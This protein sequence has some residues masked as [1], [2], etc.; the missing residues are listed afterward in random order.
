VESE[1]EAERL[2]RV[3]GEMGNRAPV[4]LRIN[5]D[6]DAKTHKKITT[7]KKENKFGIS[8]DRAMA[9]AKKMQKDMPNLVLQGLHC[10]VGSQILDPAV[11]T[12]V[13]EVVEQFTRALIAETGDY[14]ALDREMVAPKEGDLLAIRD[15]GAYGFVMASNYNTRGKPPEILT[16]DGKHY[17]VRKRE[18]VKALLKPEIVPEFR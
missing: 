13:V 11:L 6:V 8:L 2:D 4:A 9:L 15:A 3:A 12:R 5:P 1:P 7:G 16:L 14:L 18:T 17:L 10:H